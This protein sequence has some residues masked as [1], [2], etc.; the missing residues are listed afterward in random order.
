MGG[1]HNSGGALDFSKME[2]IQKRVSRVSYGLG[3][4]E[5]RQKAR[6]HAAAGTKDRRFIPDRLDDVAASI[7]A[8][9]SATAA[10]IYAAKAQVSAALTRASAMNSTI[11]QSSVGAQLRYAVA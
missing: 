10:S 3:E 8:G 5:Q 6:K 4:L 7:S 11:K 2:D 9:R 1:M